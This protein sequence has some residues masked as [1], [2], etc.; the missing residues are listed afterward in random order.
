MP[1]K[2]R[3]I[4]MTMLIVIIIAIL[5][6]FIIFKIFDFFQEKSR[7]K[8]LDNPNINIAVIGEAIGNFGGEVVN[9][10]EKSRNK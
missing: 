1:K 3:T 9:A 4:L 10:F 2:D 6:G 5:C 8:R 7:F